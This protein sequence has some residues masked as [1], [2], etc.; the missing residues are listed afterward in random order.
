MMLI[1]EILQT[2]H[3]NQ[4]ILKILKENVNNVISTVKIVQVHQ[5][6]VQYVKVQIIK[7]LQTLSVAVNKSFSQ[8]KKTNSVLVVVDFVKPVKKL[9]NV[10][11]V[12]FLGLVHLH[13][14]VFSEHFLKIQQIIPTSIQKQ[15]WNVMFNVKPVKMIQVIVKNVQQV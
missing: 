9:I 12:L 1:L 7:I 6:T 4:D 2:V 14:T 13:A 5:I 3:V 10:K 8:I 15:L 11:H